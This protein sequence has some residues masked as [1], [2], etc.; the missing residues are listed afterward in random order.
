M[1]V[2]NRFADLE[3]ALEDH[4]FKVMIHLQERGWGTSQIL[5]A[6]ESVC[7]RQRGIYEED[8]DPADDPVGRD[9]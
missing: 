3:R 2:E 8:P 6:L 7:H 4:I 1:D 5:D 9:A